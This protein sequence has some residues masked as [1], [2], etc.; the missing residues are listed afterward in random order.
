MCQ[1]P[2]LAAGL[3]TSLVTGLALSL[4]LVPP[5]HAQNLQDS[6]VSLPG[7]WAGDA[8]WGDYDRD[9]DQDLLLIGEIRQDDGTCRRIARVMRNDD[10]LLVEDVAQSDRLVGVYFGEAGW[11]DADGDGDLD[12]AIAGWDENGDESLRIYTNDEGAT[13]SDRLLSLDTGQVDDNGDPSLTGVRYADLA[14]GDPDRDGDVDLVVSGMSAGGTSLSRLYTNERGRLTLDEFNSEAL[15]NVHNGDLAWADIDNDGDLD[16]SISGENVIADGGLAAVTEFYTNEPAGTLILEPGIDLGTDAITGLSNQVKRGALSWSDFDGDGNLDLA[17]SGRDAALNAVLKIFRNRPAG[18]LSED[19][20]FSLNRFQRVDGGAHWIDYDNDGDDDLAVAGRTVLSDHRALVFENRDGSLSGVSVEEE[21]EG[22]SGG[23]T[24]WGDYDGDGKADLL[25]AG[26]DADGQ[27]RSILYSSRV[28]VANRS[29]EPPASLNEVTATSQRVLFSW[30]AGNDVESTNL[31]YNVRVG[32]E[33]GSQDVLSAEVPLG[34]GNAGLK[35]DY[36]L[37]SFLP[38]DTYFWSVQT[39]DGGL[40]RSEFT[41]EGQ[42][43]VEQF[44]SSDQRLRSLSRSAMAWGDVDDDGDVDLA[45]MGTNRSG[46]AR[47]LFYANEE[48]SLT[49]HTEAG[50]TGL[51]EGDVT[52][53]DVDGDGD[54][55]LF[56]GGQIADGNRADFLYQVSGTGTGISFDPV[57]RFRPDLDRAAADLGDIDLDGD[58]DLIYAGQSVEVANGAQVSYTTVWLNDG[59]GGYNQGF[60]GLEGLNNGDLELGDLDSDGDLD[61]LITG[62]NSSSQRRTI[63]YRNDHP[64]D[65]TDAG[66]DLEGLESSTLALGDIDRDGDLDLVLGGLTS[67]TIPFAGLYDNDGG[68]LVLRTDVTLPGIR[69]GD[70]ALADYDNDQDLDIILSGNDG[71]VALLQVWENTIG[72]AAPDSAF[73]LLA[74]ANLS[75]VDFSAVSAADLD[76]D[77]DLDLISSGRAADFSPRSAVNDNLTAQQ[78]NANLAPT[79]ASGLS[80][81]DTA[82]EVRLTWR[83]GDDDANPPVASLTYNVRVGT[84]PDADDVVSGR[85]ALNRGNAGHNLFLEVEGLGSD[86]YYWSVQTID[87]GGISSPWSTETSFVIDTV[88]PTLSGMTLSRTRLGLGQTLSLGLQFDDAHAGVDATVAPAVTATVGGQ[89]FDVTPLQFTGDAWSGEVTIAEG[90]PSGDATISVSGLSDLKGNVLVPVDSVGAFTVDALRPFVV[91][92]IPADGSNTVP[93]SDIASVIVGFSEPLDPATAISS[94]FTVRLGVLNIATTATYSESDEAVLV[95]LV[96]ETGL[97]PGS[98]YSIEV[99]AAIADVTGNIAGESATWSFQ[100]RIPTLT[101]STPAADADSVDAS[102]SRIT[103]VFDTPLFETGLQRADAARILREGI[104]VPLREAAV[105]DAASTS[106]L[107]EPEGGLRPGSNY[108]VVLTGL[109]GGPLRL[110]GEGDYTWQFATRLASPTRFSPADGDTGVSVAAST[111]QIDF[112][113]GIDATLLAED[114]DAVQLF[115]EGAPVGINPPVYDAAARTLTVIPTEGFESGSAYRAL[116]EGELLG[117]NAPFQFSWSFVTQIPLVVTS[118]PGDG[119]AVTSGPKR[120]DITF[121]SPVDADRITAQ[122]FRIDRGGRA[123]ALAQPEFLYDETTHTVSLPAIDLVAGSEYNVVVSSRVGGPQSQLPDHSFSF[124][125]EVPSV[126]STVPSDGD[127][128]IGT[129]TGLINIVFSSPVASQDPDGFALRARNLG[130]DLSSADTTFALLP[131]SS[132][133]ADSTRTVLAIAPEGGLTAFTEYEVVVDQRVL[134]PLAEEGFSWRFSTAGRLASISDGGTLSNADGSVQLYLPPNALAGSDGEIAIS[135]IAADADVGRPV[136]IAQ[137][138]QIGSA[139]RIDANGATLRKP[140]TLTISY[141]SADLGG[142]DAERLGVFVLANDGTWVRVG[143]TV[144]TDAHTVTTSVASLGTFGIFEDTSA[145]LGSIAVA[146]I[147][148]Q[149]RAFAPA[150]GSLRDQTDIS[151][152]LSNPADVTVRIFNASGRV[153]RILARDRAMG[154]GFNTVI[155]DGRD[156]DADVVA[157]GLYVVV[158]TA[159]DA[160]AEKVVAVVR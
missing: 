35:S 117:P 79:T 41:S 99:A 147:D 133:S 90:T 116:F 43:T 136:A 11:A 113:A 54:L 157:S 49:L 67:D 84:Q 124:R 132:V 63:L 102:T 16:L 105:Y 4:T 50:L 115:R 82:A 158:V 96:P 73:E 72:Q 86:T 1:G 66:A 125:T 121:S 92:S 9:G 57:L 39:I 141:E 38:P 70:L 87:A 119:D 42:F 7:V 24:L 55:D 44:V 27:R 145:G 160:Q 97:L 37:E 74:L 21:I 98:E 53:G 30:A 48:G 114:D 52:W 83:S 134:G 10:G 33:A 22:L 71:A 91:G 151:F 58:L 106:L 95:T 139:Y 89:S 65:F 129:D 61:L 13:A 8:T 135:R 56:S 159:G 34:P 120:I 94:N 130:L 3:I 107:F 148:C 15:L 76:G 111:L 154:P 77:G 28:A 153:E 17:L 108:Q 20:N 78:F 45:L 32:T 118:A 137:D 36:V 110:T 6:G 14:W 138:L 104:E 46:E 100:T 127:E 75:G 25:I 126:S 112:D 140:A 122:N 143:G 23:P 152:Q 51:T 40:A 109:V 142:V 68:D 26:V 12:V 62:V 101:A 150:G 2:R 103:A 156:D 64:G 85:R 88:A 149:P 29:P 60:G 131:I 59:D 93:P 146:N 31:S 47:T 155:W 144:D 18:T 128:G 123:I 5:A 81:S 69:A 80:S 19:L